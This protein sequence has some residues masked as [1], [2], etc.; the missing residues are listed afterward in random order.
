M[1]IKALTA[2]LENKADMR[3][4]HA[5]TA[6][7][8]KGG[9]IVMTLAAPEGA[10]SESFDAVILTLPFTK[11]RDVEGLKRLK[12]GS[13]KM[14]C[15]REL[16]YGTSAKVING[17]T[18][19]VWRSE[20]SDLPAPSNGSF[21]ADLGFQ[22]LWEESRAQ[23]GEAGII[24]DFLGGK[25][26]LAEEMPRSRPSGRASPRCRRRWPMVSTLRDRKSVV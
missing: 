18:S 16:G 11:L 25:A 3:H 14:K 20:A 17:T 13:E 22:N 8:T 5:L 15:I 9:Q 2:A 26:G 12:L 21:Y 23:P 4:G 19:R 1:L 7:D 24:M 10:T 6:L